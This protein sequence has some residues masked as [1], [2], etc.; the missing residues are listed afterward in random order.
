M[1]PPGPPV[2]DRP[3]RHQLHRTR[4]WRKPAGVVVVAR[5]GRWGNP[6][7][8]GDPDP[9][10]A[11]AIEDRARAVALYRRYLQARPELR[12][13]ARLELAGHALACWCPLDQPCHAEVLLQVANTRPDH[14]PR[15]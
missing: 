11:G 5:P 12:A 10:R 7:R 14:P 8:V 15:T 13:R 1:N 2:E 3:A 6:Y 9:D 4:G